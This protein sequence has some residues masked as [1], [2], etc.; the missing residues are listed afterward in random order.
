MTASERSA[1]GPEPRPIS[2]SAS[3][4]EPPAAVL[5]L[6]ALVASRLQ[7]R[8]PELTQRA[9]HAIEAS[10]DDLHD[11]NLRG[12]L[13]ASVEG[14]IATILQMIEHQIPIEHIQPITAATEYAIRLARGSV[15]STSL[16][17]AYH[18]GSNDMVSAMFEE[19]RKLDSPADLKLEVLRYLA[20]WMHRYVDWITRVVIDAHE[21]ERHEI[22]LLSQ[23][24]VYTA[25]E[26]VLHGDSADAFAFESRTGYPL[27]GTHIGGVI[28]L[29]ESNR[30]GDQT[31]TLRSIAN[32]IA[33]GAD[34]PAKPL[35]VPTD[36]RSAWIWI[37]A[38]S[39]DRDGLRA[40]VKAHNGLRIALGKP[41][42]RR[43]GFR[44]THQQA[45][46]VRAV[47][48]ITGTMNGRC[49][50]DG[51]DGVAIIARM[52]EDLG[53]LRGWVTEVLGPLASTDDATERLRETMV[54]FIRSLGSYV[55]TSE[56]LF[57]HRNTVKYRVQR[58]EEILG[59]PITD[60]LY[61]VGLALQ[62]CSLL[63]SAVLHSPS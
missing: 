23:H 2:D 50:M 17:R 11:A 13:R 46:D 27:T 39:V 42:E 36:N 54:V 15:S 30:V 22:L 1:G 14:N 53:A 18:F 56:S 4:Q 44:R 49:V 34:S 16:R 19:I 41:G 21:V 57:L 38:R 60:R 62:A 20:A 6:A 45:Q 28:W 47:P 63:G 31:A 24:N 52:A 8:T 40:L 3:S 10:A 29:Q 9:M 7:R 43:E 26:D 59:R 25:V 5:H 33:I 37:S 48:A 12:L 51:D 32:T 61:D 55:D 58:F 35:V